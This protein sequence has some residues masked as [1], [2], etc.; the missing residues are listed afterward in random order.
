MCAKSLAQ[1]PLWWEVEGV[2][3]GPEEGCA[4]VLGVY[5][6]EVGTV[7][8]YDFYEAGWGVLGEGMGCGADSVELC[9]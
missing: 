5:R 9:L 3:R 8:D 2:V 7:E 1:V 4:C 6:S